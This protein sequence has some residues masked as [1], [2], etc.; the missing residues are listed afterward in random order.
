VRKNQLSA[1]FRD[2][3][4]FLFTDQGKI[5][6]QVNH[7]Y[8]EDFDKLIE[9]GLYD[10]LCQKG[11]L[12]SHEE[13]AH[14]DQTHKAEDFYKIL[15]PEQLPYVS[16]PYEWCFSQLKDAAILTLNIQMEALKYGMI[17]K[18]ASA[19]NI[20]FLRGKPVFIDTLSFESYVEGEPWVAYKQF[21]QHFLAPLALIVNC[22]Y[23]L[24]NLLRANIDGIPLDLASNLLPAKSW[25]K[26]S[27]LAHIHLH[28]KTQKQFEDTGRSGTTTNA[29]KVSRLRFEGL[30][31]SLMSCINSL[32][33]KYAD[34]EWGGYYTDTNY[35]DDSM[36]HKEGVVSKFLETCRSQGKG[37]AADYGANT[38]KFSR[39]A[40]EKG[41]FVLSHDIDEV[42]VDK[43]YREMSEQS[44]QSILPLLLDLTNPSPALGWASKERSSF[45]DRQQVDVAMAL[46]IIHHI[47]ISNNVP[48]DSI[49][50]LFSAMCQSLIIEFVPKSDSQVK[51]LLATRED[52]FPEYNQEDFERIFQN[53]F[54]IIEAVPVENSERTMYLLEVNSS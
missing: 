13:T 45:I 7:S 53:Y 51:R 33:W 16:Y 46:A 47:A 25:F 39:L 35:V 50:E 11:W 52:I 44:E 5:F 38:G 3:S 14:P 10:S 20:Q 19:Y 8:K 9:S 28:A 41:F 42:A 15:M 26:Y 54:R 43:N 37:T 29:V 30:I 27:L 23:R 22:D 12:I 17:L 6:R 32:Q 24:L 1:S 49:A 2:P 48:L 40:A 18:D 4:G 31:S 36:R 34:T 21:C